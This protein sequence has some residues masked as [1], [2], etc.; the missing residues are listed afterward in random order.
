MD[1]SQ[2]PSDPLKNALAELIVLSAHSYYN[3]QP[4]C[5]SLRQVVAVDEAHRILQADFIE[6]FAL[7]CRAY[8]VCLLLS[9]QY[10]S[11]FPSDVRDCMATKIIHGNDRDVERVREIVNLLDCKG[12]ESE[13]AELGM[14]EAMYS[15]KHFRNTCVRTI[16]YPVDLVLSALRQSEG[17]ELSREEISQIP[18]FDADKLSIGNIVRHLER[19]GLAEGTNGFVR[20]LDRDI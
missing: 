4:H 8:G 5:D 17:G 11:H 9:S 16:T 15:N 12:R 14:F 10:P 13:V 18:G 20:L 3:S 19:L 6:R 2:I 1:L 7:E